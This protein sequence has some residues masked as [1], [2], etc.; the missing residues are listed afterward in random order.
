MQGRVVSAVHDVNASPSHDEHVHHVGAALPARPVE[1]A[2]AMVVS[3][4]REG[5]KE[6][7]N[8]QHSRNLE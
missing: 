3:T 7:E 5:E 8:L 6:R 1:R 2:E 4:K